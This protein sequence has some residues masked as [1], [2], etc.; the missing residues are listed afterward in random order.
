MFRTA[1]HRFIPIAL[2][3]TLML[4]LAACSETGGAPQAEGGGTEGG[5]GQV[6]DT[7]AYN[8][9]MV[10]HAP[11]GDT[12]FDIIRA[13]ADAAAAKDN[14]TYEYSNNADPSQQ[15]NLIQNAIDRGV[16]GL[17]VSMPNPAALT[18]PIRNAVEAGIPV[19]MFNAGFDAWQDTGALMYF[20]Q[21]ES[22]AGQA[23]A[24]R[25]NE[26]GAQKVLCVPQ[27]QGQAQLEARCDGVQQNV[28]GEYEK[29]Y[30]EGTNMPSVQST[31]SSKLRQD[32]SIDYLLTL[33]APFALAAVSAVEEAGSEAQVVTFDTNAELVAS[34]ES[35]DVQWAVDQQP[36]MQGYQAIDGLWYYLNNRNV[37]GGGQAVLTGPSFIDQENIAEVAE[38][39]RQGTR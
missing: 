37:L 5:G 20:G 34:I 3:A 13:G 10:T 31:I 11:Q 15:A 30:V 2:L 12:F 23:A 4:L 32:P 35:G 36:Y 29:L 39:A 18:A 21:D 22:L 6:A 19:V 7:P 16:D 38:L 17:A 8:V 9:A 27:E 25:L 26:A 33:G 28:D 14:I 1:R 24:E